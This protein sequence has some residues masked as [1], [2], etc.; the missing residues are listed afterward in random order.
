MDFHALIFAFIDNR[1]EEIEA[2]LQAFTEF[3]LFLI[4]WWIFWWI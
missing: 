2:I 3:N 4:S 1:R